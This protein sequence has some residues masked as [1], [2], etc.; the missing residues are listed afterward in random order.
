M[1]YVIKDEFG[2]CLLIKYIGCDMY[3]IRVKKQNHVSFMY[4]LQC[5]RYST[6]DLVINDKDMFILKIKKEKEKTCYIG[7]W[8]YILPS[9]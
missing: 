3:M 9:F 2:L 8:Y 6:I 1:I 4:S 7:F 5:T